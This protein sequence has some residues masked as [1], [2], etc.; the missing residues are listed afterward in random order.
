MTDRVEIAAKCAMETLR[1]S[2]EKTL[3]RLHDLCSHFAVTNN[4]L[5][6]DVLRRALELKYSWEVIA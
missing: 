6:Q 4:V 5:T 3:V 2:G 1:A